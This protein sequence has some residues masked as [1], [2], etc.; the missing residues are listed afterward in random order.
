MNQQESRTIAKP[1][2]PS[3]GLLAW[4]ACGL[5]IACAVA[6]LMAGP[7]YRL[8][9]LPLG[10]CI[11]IMRWAATIAMV[12][13]VLGLVAA[14]MALRAHMRR[15]LRI[16]LSGL[17]L[18]LAVA[19]PP[20]T[21]YV[22]AQNLPRIH[23]IST[24]TENPPPFVAIVPLRQGAPNNTIYTPETA[25]LQKKGY[26]DIKPAILHLAPE[27][28]FERAE[29]AARSM[30]WK[31]VSASLADLRIEATDTTLLFGF[32]DDIVIHIA[33]HPE[34]SRVDVRSLSRVG[35]S[36]IGVNAN[37]IRRFLAVLLAD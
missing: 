10:I 29:R 12:A 25:A 7:L 3:S 31:I 27:K 33:S 16:A 15:S 11:Q 36:D 9:W 4:I 22:R 13:A 1:D 5:A 18:A 19:V 35:V 24:D 34:G 2:K 6:A 26:P 20:I 8:S 32:K 21:L 28:A 14:I 23:D 30:D 37:R 17:I